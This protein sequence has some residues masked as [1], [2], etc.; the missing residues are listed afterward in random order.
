MADGTQETRRLAADAEGVTEAAALIRNGQLVAF[1]TETVY[2]LGGNALSN[3]ATTA[4]F[5][6]KGRPDFNPLI[7]HCADLAAAEALAEISPLARRLAEALW[8]GPLT[9]VLPR[10]PGIALADPVSAGLPTV[11]VRVPAHPTAQ[12]L[13]SK[14]SVPLA[15][16]SANPSGAVSPT[17]ADHVL[18]GL[19][20][21]IAAVL[22]A[23]PCPVGLESTILGFEGGRPVLLRPGGIP[24]EVL[25]EILGEIPASPATA[26]VQSPGQ[27]A[28]HYAPGA[29]LRLNATDLAPG[30]AWLGLGPI[31]RNAGGPVASLSVSGDLA[32]AA[33]RLYAALRGLDAALGG[34]G[35]IAVGPI[36]NT[37]LGAAINDRLQRAAAPRP[38]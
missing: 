25:A 21:R 35:T 4:I 29:A 12:A 22:D 20:G 36:P 28:S 3:A 19:G 24:A 27:L 5:R 17:T 18:E 34:H 13:L 2:G 30:E 31:P 16:P 6:A 33:S 37:G 32:E 11:A 26:A 38:G 14:A 1:P 10:R 23:G 15:A 7:V 9:L 8:P